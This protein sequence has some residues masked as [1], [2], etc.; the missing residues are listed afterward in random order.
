M[1]LCMSL[2]CTVVHIPKYMV[3]LCGFSFAMV[4][5]ILKE[6]Y[7]SMTGGKFDWEDI[8]ADLFGAIAGVFMMSFVFYTLTSA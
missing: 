6:V 1:L 3:L 4:I 5:G 7:D 2:G 8:A